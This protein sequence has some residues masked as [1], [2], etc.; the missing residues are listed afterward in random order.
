[1][2]DIDL[3]REAARVAER[4]DRAAD[5]ARER[6]AQV[7]KVTGKAESGDGSI[8]VEVSPGG[9][10][11]GVN[12]TR[13]ALRFGSDSIAQQIMEL[14]NLATRRAGDKM[15]QALA[16]VLGES[17]TKHLQSLGFEPMPDDEPHVTEIFER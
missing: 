11:A 17:G 14:S 10:L 4:A 16:P 7:G 13:S 2:A 15:Y 5:Q 6:F 1:M 12:L 8:G 9:L 3:D